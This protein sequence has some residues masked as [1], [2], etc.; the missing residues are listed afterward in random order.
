[1][2]GNWKKMN[3]KEERVKVQSLYTTDIMAVGTKLKP[4]SLLNIQLKISLDME[5]HLDKD[6]NKKNNEEF[7]KEIGLAVEDACKKADFNY[8]EKFNIK[9]EKSSLNE[10]GWY[11]L[12]EDK[13]ENL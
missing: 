13:N 3:N 10:F 8:S 2:L 1:M 4:V 6:I 12:R 11:K 5:Q 7:F 9:I